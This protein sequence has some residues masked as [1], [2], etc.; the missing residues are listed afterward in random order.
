MF[1]ERIYFLII[2]VNFVNS[3]GS[4]KAKSD[5]ETAETL[6]SLLKYALHSRQNFGYDPYLEQPEHHPLYPAKFP[7]TK[8]PVFPYASPFPYEHIPHKIRQAHFQ[9]P[10]YSRPIYSN[11]FNYHSPP[12]W[13]HTKQSIMEVLYSLSNNDDLQ[14][15]PKILCEV[16]SGGLMGRQSGTILPVNIDMESLI[17]IVS[18][19]NGVQGSPLLYFGKAA[20]LGYTSKNNPRAC[21]HAYPDCPRDPNKLVQY[22][23][24]HNGG[25][26][27]YFNGIHPTH[28]QLHHDFPFY[29]HQ[30]YLQK[31]APHYQDQH[32]QKYKPGYYRQKAIAEQRIQNKPDYYIS[33]NNIGDQKVISFPEEDPGYFR[34]QKELVFP[35]SEDHFTLYKTKNPLK[36]PESNYEDYPDQPYRKPKE[37]PFDLS[38]YQSN[39]L[40]LQKPLPNHKASKMIFP[41][42]T[43]TGELRLDLQEL[44]GS[45]IAF[46]DDDFRVKFKGFRNGYSLAGNTDTDQFV[47]GNYRG[48]KAFSFFPS[49]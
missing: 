9:K 35:P 38:F 12:T 41:D 10:Y 46:E 30:N 44:D 27:R 40:D 43:G 23:N 42:R 20:L 49:L 39:D 7:P 32:Y 31:Y 47:N 37:L 33:T 22:L 19:L 29:Q 24:N 2:S 26:F 3:G 13:E 34:A 48:G 14:C 6:G 16:T 11:A 17:G 28:M 45:S 21:D 5:N 8:Y 25:F 36:F 4:I 15:V 18:S 1:R